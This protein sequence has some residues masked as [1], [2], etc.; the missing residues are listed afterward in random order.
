MRKLL[1]LLIIAVL[2]PACRSGREMTPVEYSSPPV[3]PAARAPE[4]KP[5]P[6]AE[7]AE[8]IPVVEERFEF[9]QKQ[10]ELDHQ[11]N[12]FFV[13]L[14]SFRVSENANNFRTSLERSGFTPVILLS[15]TGLH[16]ISVGSFSQESEARQRVLQIRRTYPE[17]Y[18][19]WLLIRRVM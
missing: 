12:S 7:P 18:D 5:E 13:I 17:Y 2:L 9:E 4:T 19:A 14:G 1:T 6:V 3:R 11:V 16:R 8:V 15:E 10:D